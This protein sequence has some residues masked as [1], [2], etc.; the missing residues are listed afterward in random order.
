MAAQVSAGYHDAAPAPTGTLLAQGRVAETDGS[1][2]PP[3]AEEAAIA[4][5]I[6]MTAF[7]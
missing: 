1:E 4:N 5:V 7:L 2:D 3:A 6:D